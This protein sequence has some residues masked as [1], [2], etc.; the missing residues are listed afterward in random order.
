MQ[1]EEASWE[2]QE[3][4]V[5]IRGPVM[6][7]LSQRSGRGRLSTGQNPPSS[8][9]PESG[10]SRFTG[11]NALDSGRSGRREVVARCGL[12]QGG[13]HIERSR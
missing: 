7:I 9:S 12:L 4:P 3:A 11:V 6:A 13:P 5:G 10:L 8:P 1:S 2:A